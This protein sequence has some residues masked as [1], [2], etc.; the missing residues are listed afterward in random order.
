MCG[1]FYGYNLKEYDSDLL[2]ESSDAKIEDVKEGGQ[3]IIECTL[4]YEDDPYDENYIILILS[5]VHS[6]KKKM[7]KGHLVIT[8]L[9]TVNRDKNYTRFDTFNYVKSSNCYLW[10][11]D[12]ES[13]CSI[14]FK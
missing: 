2:S 6:V 12:P 5:N 4:K 1:L 7:V 11:E 10:T 14:Y 3:V 9:V 13:F 8:K